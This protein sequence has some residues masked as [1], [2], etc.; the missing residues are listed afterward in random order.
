MSHRIT[1]LYEP[2]FQQKKTLCLLF[3]ISGVLLW[4]ERFV[5]RNSMGGFIV[6][7]NWTSRKKTVKKIKNNNFKTNLNKMD[8]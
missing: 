8:F 5:W 3:L 4:V 7:C 1:Q 6:G 2:N